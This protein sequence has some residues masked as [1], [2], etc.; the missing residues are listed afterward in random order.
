MRRI[1]QKKEVSKSKEKEQQKAIILSVN[2]S[3]KQKE[4]IESESKQLKT[5]ILQDKR[6]YADLTEQIKNLKKEEGSCGSRVKKLKDEILV[7]EEKR[8]SLQINIDDKTSVLKSIQENIESEQKKAEKELRRLD[9]I[10]NERHKTLHGEILTVE[11]LLADKRAQLDVASKSEE[12]I[13]QSVATKQREQKAIDA[14]IA[15]RVQELAQINYD[16]AETEAQKRRAEEEVRD[17]KKRLSS[18]E[19]EIAVFDAEIKAKEA[20]IQEAEV[21]ALNKRKEIVALIKREKRL[22]ELIPTI[23]DLYAKAGIT[24]DI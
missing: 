3:K 5:E 18:I 19:A 2:Q 8:D 24:I 7:L 21:Q 15:K 12:Q 17:A 14:S 20:K 10:K 22:E 9:D 23:R 4:V 16:L 6:L 11:K 1:F 13:A